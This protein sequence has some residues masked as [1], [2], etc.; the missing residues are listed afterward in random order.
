MNCSLN[1]SKLVII[2]TRNLPN[3]AWAGPDKVKGKALHRVVASA[4]AMFIH[5]L[6]I[7]TW[8]TGSVFP[9]YRGIVGIL[10]FFEG[11]VVEMLV[12]KRD[13]VS[14]RISGIRSRILR[15]ASSRSI[16]AYICDKRSSSGVARTR[17]LFSA[18]CSRRTLWATNRARRSVLSLEPAER[19]YSESYSSSMFG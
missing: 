11:I 9:S 18:C 3:H 13:C 17:S 1:F 10:K 15:S 14:E 7:W 2:P 8:A 4:L 12:G 5:I 6:Y 19:S 16:W